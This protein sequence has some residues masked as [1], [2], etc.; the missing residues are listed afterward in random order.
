M[1]LLLNSYVSRLPS[2]QFTSLRALYRTG[3]LRRRLA[4]ALL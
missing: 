3:R 4:H 2:D 1:Q